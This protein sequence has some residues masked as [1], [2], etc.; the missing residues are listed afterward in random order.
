MR[1]P[2]ESLQVLLRRV[3]HP[4]AHSGSEVTAGGCHRWHHQDTHRSCGATGWGRR[5]PG[6]HPGSKTGSLLLHPGPDPRASNT[7]QETVVGSDTKI[8]GGPRVREPGLSFTGAQGGLRG[9]EPQ[10]GPESW[11]S[12]QRR[13]AGH[14]TG[15]GQQEAAD[16]DG[17]PTRVHRAGRPPWAS[18]APS[19]GPRPPPGTAP[20]TTSPR[21]TSPGSPGALGGP[22]PPLRRTHRGLPAPNRAF[23]HVPNP[24]PPPHWPGNHSPKSQSSQVSLLG[25]DGRGG[26]RR[27]T[28]RGTGLME[29]EGTR[30]G[31]DHNV[32]GASSGLNPR[33]AAR[34]RPLRLTGTRLGA[35]PLMAPSASHGPPALRNTPR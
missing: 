17:H 7:G 24:P 2:S 28:H 14:L 4:T 5:M 9:S 22:R 20:G 19:P 8:P 16:G 10:Q 31:G 29:P 25:P 15:P 11:A 32:H 27:E 1:V 23:P 13:A 21:S 26:R 3:K 12:G 6:E 33:Y 35:Q 30:R 18:R 34:P